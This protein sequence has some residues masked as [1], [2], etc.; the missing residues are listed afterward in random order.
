MSGID[1]DNELFA[2]IAEKL[3][4]ELAAIIHLRPSPPSSATG[5]LRKSPGW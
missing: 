2:Q 3:H 5:G 4:L 1:A